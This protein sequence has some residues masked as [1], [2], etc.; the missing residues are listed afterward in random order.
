MWRSTTITSLRP[1]DGGQ[2]PI[3]LTVIVF[4]LVDS[5]IRTTTLPPR[6]PSLMT[7]AYRFNLSTYTMLP[8]SSPSKA[9]GLGMC[10]RR[11]IQVALCILLFLHTNCCSR[12][13]IM[14]MM[15][16]LFNW[17]YTWVWLIVLLMVCW[18]CFLVISLWILSG[19]GTYQVPN[20]RYKGTGKPATMCWDGD[21]DGRFL[22]VWPMRMGICE[23]KRWERWR[24]YISNWSNGYYTN[25]YV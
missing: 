23:G 13:L 11:H 22:L 20:T 19:V 10:H 2:P 12:W 5:Q 6:R 15:C 16:L 9:N 1:L 4:N 21:G 18:C 24:N 17:S 25:K 8:S 7:N 3:H 14:D